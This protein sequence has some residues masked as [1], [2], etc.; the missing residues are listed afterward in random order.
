MLARRPGGLGSWGEK[1]C[2]RVIA[3]G[4]GGKFYF[5]CKLPNPPVLQAIQMFDLD[6]MF[7]ENLFDTVGHVI[8]MD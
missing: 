1:W 3:P 7:H 6:I 5:H 8:I 4:K 2:G